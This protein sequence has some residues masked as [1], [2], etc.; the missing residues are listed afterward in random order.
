[1][2]KN[3]SNPTRRSV[4]SS[5]RRPAWLWLGAGT[6][7]LLALILGGWWWTSQSAAPDTQ[8][9]VAEAYTRYQA[10]TTFFLD[11]RTSEEWAQFHLAYSTLIPLAE[12]PDRLSELPRDRPIVTVCRTGRRSLEAQGILQRAGFA[13]VVSLT[14]GVM[15]WQAAGYPTVTGP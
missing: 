3:V 7:V 6:A 4:R 11:V 15:A 14:G 1:M 8:I 10:G 2:A 9:T 5:S 12:L 13:D